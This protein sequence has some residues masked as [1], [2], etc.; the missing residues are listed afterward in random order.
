MR[1]HR[2]SALASLLLIS[3]FSIFVKTANAEP[4][5]YYRVTVNPVA[6]GLVVHSIVDLNWSVSFQA[7][8]T[9]GDNSGQRIENATL[10][11]EVRTENDTLVENLQPKTN[12][13]G[14]VSFYY[15]SSTPNALTFTPTK[16]ITEDGVDWNSSLLENGEN[17]VYGF[18]S[19]PIMIYWDIFDISLIIA[20]TNT[21]GVTKVSVNITYLMI[22]Q[23]GLAVPQLSNQSNYDYIPKYVHDADV[24]INGVRA[25]ESSTSGVYAAETTTWLPT[26]YVIVGV[27]QQDWSQTHRAFSTVHG[28]NEIVWASAG[29]LGLVCVVVLLT[30]RFILFKKTKDHLLFDRAYYVIVGAILL[31]IASFLSVYWTLVGLEGVLHGFDWVLLVIFGVIASVGGFVGCVMSRRRRDFA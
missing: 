6:P 3:V 20:D 30:H 29:I 10:F 31:A 5:S 7:T 12:A 21:L 16:L 13:T 22:P 26:A 19:E 8:W 11:I 15:S 2:I 4:T 27:S 24:T 17:P 18:Q 28:A 1:S 23:E 14:F 9:Y 25:E